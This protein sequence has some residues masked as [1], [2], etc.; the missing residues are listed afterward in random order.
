MGVYHRNFQVVWEAHCLEGP[1]CLNRKSCRFI[2]IQVA[3]RTH[4]RHVFNLA[5]AFTRTDRTM[6]RST[7]LIVAFFGTKGLIEYSTASW[8]FPKAGSTPSCTRCPAKRPRLVLLL[9]PLHQ[10]MRS[11]RAQSSNGRSD[12]QEISG[13]TSRQISG[14][15]V[16]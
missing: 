5:L 8:P 9:R 15:F 3:R 16:C 14:R 7:V 4:N 6:I 12:R 2:H 13:G 11:R 10:R 1:C